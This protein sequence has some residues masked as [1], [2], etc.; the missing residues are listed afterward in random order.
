MEFMNNLTGFWIGVTLAT[1]LLWMTIGATG[2]NVGLF[3]GVTA[4]WLLLGIIGD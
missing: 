2:S 4:C 1:G 3:I